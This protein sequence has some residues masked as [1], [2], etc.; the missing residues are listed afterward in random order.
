ML[1][2]GVNKRVIIIKNPESEIFEEVY[3]IVKSG[4]G[5][6]KQVKEN[7]MVME[8][9]RIISDYSRQQKNLIEKEKHEKQGKSDSTG[10]T[11]NADNA[12]NTDNTEISDKLDKLDTPDKVDKTDKTDKSTDISGM[13]ADIDRFLNDKIQSL[14]KPNINAKSNSKSN[15]NP[16]SNLTD[17]EIFEDGILPESDYC[18]HTFDYL[19]SSI[20]S[21]ISND[22]NV[23][24]VSGISGI[25]GI[26]NISDI[27]GTNPK[28]KL[29]S[30]KKS[31]KFR[32]HGL[33]LSLPPKSFFAGIGFMSAVVIAIR[34]L[35]F[36]FAR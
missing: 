4:K 14:E 31:R 34:V 17:E 23:D 19:P 15:P 16:M 33:S 7:E 29:I 12:D 21:D 3:F 18:A 24:N 35:E 5:F 13:T 25:S 22:T 36:I 20:I 26:S 30:S 11:D 8:A 28:F 27:Y 1:L 2:K 6:F 10:S 9:N 32:K